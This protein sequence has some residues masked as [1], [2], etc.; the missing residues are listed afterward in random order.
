M[1]SDCDGDEDAKESLEENL[2]DM[3]DLG[4]LEQ[5][6]NISTVWPHEAND[7]TPWLAEKENM[8]L[9]SEAVGIPLTMDGTEVYVGGPTLDMLAHTV[10]GSAVLIENQYGRSDDTHLG[11]LFTYS[12]G[13]ERRKGL[14][15]KTVIW[16]AED[17][18][19]YHLDVIRWLNERTPDSVVFL[20]VRIRLVKI[21][22]SDPAPVF[23][24]ID[25]IERPT[26]W[27]RRKEDIVWRSGLSEDQRSRL[28]FWSYYAKRYPDDSVPA[29]HHRTEAR[30]GVESWDVD[31]ALCLWKGEIAICY[32]PSG[33]NT[34]AES[35]LTRLRERE[36]EMRE[37]LGVDL[38]TQWETYWFYKVL[39]VDPYDREKWP[40]LGEWIHQRLRE[41]R[42]ALADD[43]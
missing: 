24:L 15:V 13:L 36:G 35:P 12:A 31:I 6:E 23:E 18:Y 25:A 43:E 11:S 5:V 2:E 39:R 16:I 4:R 21:G 37:R 41:Y 14:R 26:K 20:A 22:D 7:F 27:D 8:D 40:E 19:E 1:G 38:R 17:F 42:R 30:C 29:G 32:R 34:D 10:D 3:T 28:G 33:E 9:L